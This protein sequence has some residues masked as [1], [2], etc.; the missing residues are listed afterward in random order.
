MGE[1]PRG[2][3]GACSTLHWISVTPS[4][5]HNQIGP[6]W[7]WFPSGWACARPTPLWVS[8]MTSPVRLGVSP[9]AAPVPRD[10][11]NLRFECLFPCAGA[12]GCAV[13]FVPR[14]LSRFICARMWGHRVLPAALPAPFS[15]T[16]S[17][18]LSVYLCANVGPQGLLVIVLPTPFI[19]HSASLSS[20][21]ATRVLSARLPVSAP[22]TGLNE[23]L[24]F[25]S[26]MSDFLA[27]RFSVSSGCARRR[28]VSTYAAILVLLS[29]F[30]LYFLYSIV[31]IISS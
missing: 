29:D 13:C 30:S 16:L 8:P 31:H 10:V 1:G 3:N 25:I 18:A 9:A 24:F 22:H 20:A 2:S 17:P 27:V 26:V 15:T 11:F 28:S 7:C 19:P 23:Y 21:T 4:A 14:C 12:L 6:L 5:T